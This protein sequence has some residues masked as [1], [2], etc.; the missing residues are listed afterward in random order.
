MDGERISG[1]LGRMP[2]V[3][4]VD[5]YADAQWAYGLWLRRAGY[6][7]AFASTGEEALAQARRLRPD[8]VIMD[9]CLRGTDGWTAI[10]DIRADYDLEDVPIVAMSGYGNPRYERLAYECGCDLFLTK[11]CPIEKV[12]SVLHGL[13]SQ[14]EAVVAS[15][16]RLRA[17]DEHATPVDE[18][19]KR[20]TG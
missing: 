11:T 13:L 20:S 14:G 2:L 18:D 6:R 8:V 3:L 19:L 17:A 1:V 15:G 10:R 4:V 12:V 9:L 16:A 7:V 5:D